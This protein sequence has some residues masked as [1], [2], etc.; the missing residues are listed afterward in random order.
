MNK[1]LV[2]TGYMGS[3]SSAVTD[4][5]AEID[6]C[7]ARNGDFEFVFLHCPNG[8]FDL[9][10]KLLRGNNALRSDEALHSFLGT[11][12]ELY[13][14]KYWW[15]GHYN[16]HV[17]P[18]FYEL[19]HD[20][21]SELTDSRPDYYW[22]WQENTNTRMFFQLCLRRLV[23]LLTLK[24][25]QLRKPRTYYDTMLS[26]PTEE[27][28]YSAAARFISRVMDEIGLQEHSIVLDQ[29]LLPHNLFRVD[30]YFGDELRVF[31]VSRDP[32]DVFIQNKYVWPARN[33]AVIFPTDAEEFARF[34]R[35][36][37]DSERPSGSAKV[38]KLQ[39]EDL[40]YDYDSSMEQIYA[41]LGV[42][43]AQHSAP[44]MHFDP[45]KS[46]QNTQLF[47]VNEQ[48]AREAETIAKI[49]PEYIYDFPYEKVPDPEKS[50]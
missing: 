37:R 45:A 48:Y 25:V 36:L 18:K 11:M 16:E 10:D 6:G 27:E 7:S 4:I 49:L 35:R 24:K 1:I 2:P 9:E 50:F 41:F 40:V 43:K 5:L 23:S 22:Y 42:T 19:C 15:V 44:K 39:F 33:A 20:F 31:E 34:Y 13:S 3:G 12:K 30:K 46:I 8:V 21:V 47:R 26:I 17:G 29:L 14:K 38:L 28:F 32:R